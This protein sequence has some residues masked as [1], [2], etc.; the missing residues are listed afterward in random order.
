MRIK[1]RIDNGTP[2]LMSGMVVRIDLPIGPETMS[3]FVPTDAIVLDGLEQS[4]FVVDVDGPPTGGKAQTGVVRN[5][6]VKLGAAD[7]EWIAV[8]GGLKPDEM[9]VTR[10]N[11][12]L[13]AGQTVEVTVG[14]G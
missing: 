3:S 13:T 10:G 6:P 7:G 2:M 9:V 5:V 14:D 4:V 1:N 11:E 12:R 8:T